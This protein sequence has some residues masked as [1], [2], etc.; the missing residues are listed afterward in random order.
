M[1]NILDFLLRT[2]RAIEERVRLIKGNPRPLAGRGLRAVVD[3]LKKGGGVLQQN[4]LDS[5]LKKCHIYCAKSER[6]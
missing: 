2:E 5:F 6:K 1:T 3:L 4:R